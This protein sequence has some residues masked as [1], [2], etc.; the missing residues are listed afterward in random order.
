LGGLFHSQYMENIWK[1]IKAMFQSP[2]TSNKSLCLAPG[3]PFGEDETLVSS[4]LKWRFWVGKS[5]ENHGKTT[6][7]WRFNGKNHWTGGFSSPCL[8]GN[9]RCFKISTISFTPYPLIRCLEILVLL[10]CHVQFYTFFVSKLYP[11]HWCR[12]RHRHGP[13]TA[14]WTAATCWNLRSPR[15][16]V[17]SQLC[18][19]VSS[20]NALMVSPSG[21][22]KTVLKV[23]LSTVFVFLSFNL[24]WQLIS[25][26]RTLLQGV[27]TES[28]RPR[29]RLAVEH[30]SIFLLHCNKAKTSVKGISWTN[31]TKN[32]TE[33]HTTTCLTP[34]SKQFFSWV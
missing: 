19:A 12:T 18:H 21:G 11:K 28:K 8:I 3:W 31:R 2:P 34:S 4:P 23:D 27:V 30:L 13:S 25:Q 6:D 14:T 9:I 10:H 24:C 16:T 5:W 26:S 32:I 15:V 29:D 22:N 1:V 7:E 20:I 33:Y 17:G